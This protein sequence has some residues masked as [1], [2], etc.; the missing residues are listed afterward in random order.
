MP[1][2][3]GDTSELEGELIKRNREIAKVRDDVLKA[4]RRLE[5]T[6]MR[7]DDL[8]ERVAELDAEVT[9]KNQRIAELV[10]EVEELKASITSTSAEHRALQ[11]SHAR[12]LEQLRAEHAQKEDDWQ[13]EREKTVDLPARV[14]ELEEQTQRL[15][16]ELEEERLHHGA[17]RSTLDQV[18]ASS[19]ESAGRA[20][21]L[22][23][24]VKELEEELSEAQ[25]SVANVQS[26]ALEEERTKMSA[27]L[28]RAN[29]LAEEHLSAREDL[30]KAANEHER[31]HSEV[32]S[33][34]EDVRRELDTHRG[35][36]AELEAE[37]DE[38]KRQHDTAKETYEEA[39]VAA[40][41]RHED[42]LK[43]AT[44]KAADLDG[45]LNGQ[46]FMMQ[47]TQ[48]QLDRSE[49]EEERLAEELRQ[50]MEEIASLK[51][52]SGSALDKSREEAARDVAAA[53]E[54]FKAE[55]ESHEAF[56]SRQVRAE[57]EEHNRAVI[58]ANDERQRIEKALAAL[59][60]DH[61]V[62]REAH[63][64][65]QDSMREQHQELRG[66][67]SEHENQLA[68][69]K[70]EIEQHK[71]DLEEK[72]LEVERL[73]MAH[74]LEVERL[75][76]TL[77]AE[78][79][80]RSS[81][82]QI[83]QSQLEEKD[84]LIEHSKAA[85]ERM[86][87]DVE[88]HKRRASE[89]EGNAQ[90]AREEGDARAGQLGVRIATLEGELKTRHERH[91]EVEG[92]LEAQRQ[93]LE[94]LNEM[95]AEAQTDRDTLMATKGS[96]E[97]QLAL[98]TS[99]KD[100]VNY[101]L[102]QSQLEAETRCRELEERLHR[103]RDSHRE[104]IEDVRRS[105]AAELNQ[106]A[107]RVS[108]LE[109][110][111]LTAR[112]R[113]ELLQRNK[114]DLQKDLMEH[115]D[116][117]SVLEAKVQEHKSESE[118][119]GLDLDQH[120]QRRTQQ[121]EE[122]QRH[123]QLLRSST[124]TVE[125]L[126]EQVRTAEEARDGHHADFQSKVAKLDE[127]L[128]AERSHRANAERALTTH[129]QDAEQKHAELQ[130]ERRRSEQDLKA[131]VESWRSTA[132]RA[133]QELDQALE[134]LRTQKEQ[135]EAL[136]AK[137]RETES[138]LRGDVATVE[139]RLRRIEGEATRAQGAADEAKAS[140]AQQQA[141]LTAKI[142]ALERQLEQ[143]RRAASEH[144]SAKESAEKQVATN[145][146]GY[147]QLKE[148]CAMAAEELSAR[149]VKFTLDRQRLSGALEES[150]RTLRSTLGVPNPG[151]AVDSV[152][153]HGLEQQLAEER[154]KAI[155]KVVALQRAERRVAQLEDAQRR[156]DSAHSDAASR[157][158]ESE[159]RLDT[160]TEELR[161]AQVKQQASDQ[162]ALESRE[163]ALM[164][165]AEMG[166]IRYE[167]KY[168]AVRLRGALD[169]L[170]YMIKMQKAAK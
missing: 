76:Q 55:M 104:A 126:K 101:S 159:R 169:E 114:A 120:R 137:R 108:A 9:K 131:Q 147:K 54:R 127:L 91:T 88:D 20:V 53:R 25:D 92:R 105:F 15:K 50:R 158:R 109:A 73:Q 84:T 132:E 38:V 93:Y 130:S 77:E 156:N 60:A 170:R 42:A 79:Q 5:E 122:L 67:L 59:Q 141:S 36:V 19:R 100:A 155:E 56:T 135:A 41:Q 8:L 152:R 78:A 149:Q 140:L 28:H 57:I 66:K 117:H 31:R 95:L 161:R 86:E 62:S 151:A 143:E 10:S 168:E 30:E 99:H 61:D 58:E 64:R 115:K 72:K 34:L 13:Q 75:Q 6:Q 16:A 98:E 111:L 45:R 112:Q 47:E 22:R 154:R 14:K 65:G 52:E 124:Q 26:H 37:R 49:R 17:T 96:L 110:E 128:E 48:D 162:R 4:E 142:S 69:H 165:V 153:L 97:A 150:R 134:R 90:K 157:A 43:R 113:C 18:E 44:Q 129:K 83:F 119:L 7:N 121:D 87:R 74:R 29:S 118:R 145:A 163:Q 148:R 89:H 2:Q 33:Q 81:A 102:E 63:A 144:L 71:K 123:Q 103:D 32:S 82:E 46:R 40:S 80:S 27:A 136:D 68:L 35:S 125:E 106:S 167:S 160:L 12:E 146:D 23:A 85:L 11:G 138:T 116:R 70:E 164:A 3:L 166:T 1:S 139:A 51:E 107:E 21:D 133:Q 24:R 39:L 94:Q